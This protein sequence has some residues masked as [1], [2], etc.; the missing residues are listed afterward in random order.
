MASDNYLQKEIET[1][2]KEKDRLIAEGEG[3]FVVISNDNIVG[4]WDT[5][6]DALKAGYKE[7]G[8]K[9]FLVKQILR[10]DKVHF[11]TRDLSLCPS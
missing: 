9:P 7:F 11:F 5:Y 6:E 4:I 3:R 2:E 8:L 1:Y 10:I